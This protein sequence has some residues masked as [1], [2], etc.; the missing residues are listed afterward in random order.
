MV[1][2]KGLGQH[3]RQIPSLRSAYPHP[4]VE[5]NP[6]TATELGIGEG[7][8]V[9]IEAP[10]FKWGV[11]A[12]AKFLPGLHPQTVSM[13]PHWWFPE[14]EAPEHGCFESNINSIISYG[15][16]YDPF[17]GAHQS[18]AIPCRIRREHNPLP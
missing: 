13:L 3:I 12:K 9:S 2:W 15:A 11:R 1:T 4:L 17:T 16:P 5:I 14:K 6:A 10:G 7:D 8:M 18:R